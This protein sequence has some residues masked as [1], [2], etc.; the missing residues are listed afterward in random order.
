MLWDSWKRES[1]MG[2][3]KRQ[4]KVYGL[5]AVVL[6]G[7]LFAGCI[8]QPDETA[9]DPA[10]EEKQEP[11]VW[12]D[13]LTNQE[14]VEAMEI[15]VDQIPADAAADV[16]VENGIGTSRLAETSSDGIDLQVTWAVPIGNLP[17]AIWV[18]YEGDEDGNWIKLDDVEVWSE[19]LEVEKVTRYG[20]RR[21]CNPT[22]QYI[23][24]FKIQ[25]N[26][27]NGDS[28]EN[29]VSFMVWPEPNP[30]R[31]T[32]SDETS[33]DADSTI[34]I[35]FNDEDYFSWLLPGQTMPAEQVITPEDAPV[36]FDLQ[37]LFSVKFK[38]ETDFTGWG[39]DEDTTTHYSNTSFCKTQKVTDDTVPSDTVSRLRVAFEDLPL[40]QVNTE[41][42]NKFDYDDVILYVD[43]L[44]P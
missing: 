38:L 10:D 36:N 21:H 8:P 4:P 13:G 39:F 2:K 40:G 34:S 12:T 24:Y 44:R 11:A 16:T 32:L 7:L 31:I 20:F 6:T 18:V 23:K 25:M 43:F 15:T 5:F 30:V 33:A 1:N 35:L 3:L 17:H 26:D 14:I 29:I 28:Y 27:E 22:S 37:P 42:G 19:V 9:D 41:P